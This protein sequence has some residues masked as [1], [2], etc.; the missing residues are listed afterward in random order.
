ME[1]AEQEVA[2]LGVL[3]REDQVGGLSVLPRKRLQRDGVAV[4]LGG[5]VVE[6]RV[7]LGR[8]ALA[9]RVQRPGDAERAYKRCLRIG[10][11][12]DAYAHL[13]A[14]YA[15]AR[16]PR[17]EQALLVASKLCRGDDRARV[18]T[19]AA[20]AEAAGTGDCGDGSAGK[21]GACGDAYVARDVAPRSVR[22][23]IADIVAAVGVSGVR[24]AV[25][26]VHH[27]PHE[28]VQAQLREVV[29][30]KLDGHDR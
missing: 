14:L 22:A 5:G 23:A 21:G 9:L 17:V 1:A 3:V 25:A 18:A 12:R 10:F 16:P 27:V 28:L 29:T 30:W 4:D 24:A 26:R 6:Q 13:L 2:E 11:S 7:W 15:N 8:G 20:T 19:A